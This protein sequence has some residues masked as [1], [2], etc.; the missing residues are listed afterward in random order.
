MTLSQTQNRRERERE[1]R[2]SSILSA[3]RQVFFSHGIHNATMD[4]VAAAAEVSKGTVYL[5]FQSKETVLATLLQE[6]LILL[7]KQLEAAYGAEQSLAA[8]T[9]LQRI[10]DTY[11]DFFQKYPHYC[12]LLIMFDRYKFKES[13]DKKLYAQTFNYNYRC[14]TYVVR[15]LE[16]G[17]ATGEIAIDDPLQAA[18]VIWAMLHGVYILLGPPLRRETLN[19][20]L[21]TLYY[22]AV[23]LTIRGLIAPQG[24]ETSDPA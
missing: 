8:V 15:A 3:A 9:R 13:V 4:D 6:G 21:K 1:E 14:L 2:Q 18:S 12:R 17:A 16:Q 5:Y 24:S 23:E 10:A 7:V 11:F 20:D 19:A 22:S